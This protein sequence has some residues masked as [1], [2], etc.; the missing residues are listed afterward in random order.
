MPGYALGV[1]GLINAGLLLET[2]LLGTV[3]DKAMMVD[4]VKTGQ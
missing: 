3:G 2:L 4:L 1:A